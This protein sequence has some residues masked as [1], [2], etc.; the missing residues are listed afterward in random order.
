[1]AN[2]RN[3]SGSASRG[4]PPA[5]EG[6]SDA[7]QLQALR[8]LARSTLLQRVPELPPAPLV[9]LWQLMEDPKLLAGGLEDEEDPFDVSEETREKIFGLLDGV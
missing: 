2:G 8:R 6:T 5:M 1:M 7:E 3:G 4:C 9:R